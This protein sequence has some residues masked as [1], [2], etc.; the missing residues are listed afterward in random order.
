MRRHGDDTNGG[1]GRLRRRRFAVVSLF[2]AGVL[3]AAV[4]YAEPDPEE[5]EDGP[6][7][8]E[9]SAPAERDTGDA[10]DG[11]RFAHEAHT[12]LDCVRCHG[13]G[14]EDPDVSRTPG[15]ETCAECHG[16][17][18]DEGDG[19][20]ATP[21][22]RDCQGCHV[23]YDRSVDEVIE[24]PEDWRSV[25]PAPMIPP[26]GD[27]GSS[28]DHERHLRAL[29]EELE[30]NEGRDAVC[31]ECH[32][33]GEPRIPGPASCEECH[34]DE[35]TA[36]G[37]MKPANHTVDWMQRHGRVARSG[38]D[39]CD[40]CHTEDDC[41]DCHDS[42]SS[43]PFSVHPPN[44]D[45]LHAAEARADLD[46]CTECHTV[47]TFCKRCHAETNFAPDPPDQPPVGYDVHP[48]SW[49]EPGAPNN[50][51]VMA[52]RNIED[53]ASCHTERDCVSCH[54]GVNPHPPDFQL[55]CKQWLESNPAPCAKCHGNLSEI[56]QRCL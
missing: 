45:T 40:D 30:G 34:G 7:K 6:E 11:I 33:E 35:T 24:S 20:A 44:F 18:G 43:E 21:R 26:R 49:T 54:Q 13:G 19:E 48:D 23:G 51:A 16:P 9:A 38:T 14:A 47:E 12:D 27:G 31:A 5:P 22:L 2:V 29:G 3:T 8:A 15:M 1:A 17:S 46:D 52:R 41:N 37:S 32:G 36:T 10:V 28:F 39:S 25:D 53:C 4:A 50:H 42:Q 55:R 56:R